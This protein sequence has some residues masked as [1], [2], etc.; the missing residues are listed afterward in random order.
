MIDYY[1]EEIF[2]VSFLPVDVSG[3]DTQ[4]VNVS[5][6][7]VNAESVRPEC[8]DVAANCAGQAAR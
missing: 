1:Q 5:A 4:S 7:V 2:F 6:L 8:V 3:R